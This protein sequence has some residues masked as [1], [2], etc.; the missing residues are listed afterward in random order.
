MQSWLDEVAST[1]TIDGCCFFESRSKQRTAGLL[2]ARLQTTS[3]HG[4][5]KA[6]DKCQ[7]A[8]LSSHPSM[9][10]PGN[11][12]EKYNRLVSKV[13]YSRGGM[14]LIAKL[15]KELDLKG[16]NETWRDSNADT[17]ELQ[18]KVSIS[19]DPMN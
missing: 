5:D 6:D 17:P 9:S 13:S 18:S 1:Y 4:L 3:C 11:P 7:R 19:N 12:K 14:L 8:L 10:T 16:G 2:Q 15:G